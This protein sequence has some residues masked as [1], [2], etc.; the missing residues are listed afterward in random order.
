MSVELTPEAINTL[1]GNPLVYRRLMLYTG[2]LKLLGD[3][4]GDRKLTDAE[5]DA[6]RH[7]LDELRKW[8]ESAEE[9][10]EG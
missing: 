4:Y 10:T 5:H 2:V 6:F 3:C 1:L 7:H 8:W 9:N